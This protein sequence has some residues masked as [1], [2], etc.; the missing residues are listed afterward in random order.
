VRGDAWERWA[1][2]VHMH[3]H[4]HASSEGALRTG[5]R[6]SLRAATFGHM[7][8]ARYVRVAMAMMTARVRL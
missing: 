4:E 2:G 8:N 5:L 1:D 3:E 7:R 6:G